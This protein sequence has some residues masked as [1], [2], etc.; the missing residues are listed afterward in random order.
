M[1]VYVLQHDNT[2]D[3]SDV[4]VAE[5]SAPSLQRA[6]QGF[7][8]PG[9]RLQIWT[10]EVCHKGLMTAVFWDSVSE[11]HVNCWIEVKD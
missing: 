10:I 11:K 7:M 9:Y 5:I 3:Y 4:T 1:Q 8:A 2:A 6:F